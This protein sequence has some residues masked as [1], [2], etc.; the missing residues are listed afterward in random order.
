MAGLVLPIQTERL[1]LRAHRPDDLESL[2][3]YYSDPEVAR[4]I[5]WQPWSRSEAEEHLQKRL[6]RTGID[7][8]DSAAALVVEHGQRVIG[9]VVLWP[10]DETLERGE[11][12][13]AFHPAAAGHG[14]ATEAVQALIDVAFG[15]Y[16]MRRVIAQVDS[17]NAASAKLCAR[18]GM[19][20]EAYLRQDFW[21]K[22][23]WTDNVIYGL[24]ASE[25]QG[26]RSSAVGE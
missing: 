19:R 5:P 1:R 16:G 25:W 18:I 26:L 3:D 4:Y 13:W 12:G 20:R 6:Q 14:Y 23:E 24:L 15:T 10:A 8:S 21:A 9:D 7:R 22:G 11:M 17:R 2:L